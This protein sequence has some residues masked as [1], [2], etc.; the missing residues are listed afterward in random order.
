MSDPGIALYDPDGWREWWG[1]L[2]DSETCDP[3]LAVFAKGC[4]E[5]PRLAEGVGSKILEVD[6]GDG[7]VDVEIKYALKDYRW[8]CDGMVWKPAR[9]MFRSKRL[10]YKQN[11]SASEGCFRLARWTQPSGS[12][13]KD[14]A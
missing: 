2:H 14:G 13:P 7:R 6:D 10:H 5:D 1:S 11:R 12:S 8:G 4:L 3:L 9:S